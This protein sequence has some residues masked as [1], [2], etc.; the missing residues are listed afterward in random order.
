MN[1]LTKNLLA[2][3]CLLLAFAA[4]FAQAEDFLD[5]EEAFKFSARAIDAQTIEATWKIADGYYLYRDKFKF[6][7]EG[8]KLGAAQ[9]PAGKIKNDP[10]FGSVEIY[11]KSVTIKL[12]VNRA[13]GGILPVNLQATFQGCAEDGVCYM[14]IAG[15]A[16]LKLAALAAPKE[17]PTAAKPAA[18]ATQQ[19]ATQSVS[20]LAGLR[21][22]A[23]DD[24]MGDF[25][26]PDEAF[27]S[28]A[29]LKDAQTLMVAYTIAKDYYLYRDKL[30]FVIKAPADVTAGKL[31]TP[32]PDVKDDPTFGRTE[33]YH[34]NFTAEAT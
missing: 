1:H 8:A 13:P 3:P 17:N 18:E 6:S 10:T 28:N 15:T 2:L 21:T 7:L 34:H 11:K 22:L 29:R 32:A 25:L 31:A 4:G 12:P 27:K 14:P 26:P 9:Y 16:A 23:G 24:G 20:A 5:P 30:N 19:S 33:V